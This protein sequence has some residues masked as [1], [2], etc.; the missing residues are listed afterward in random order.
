MNTNEF[1]IEEF[2]NYCCPSCNKS[3]ASL[4]NKIEQY[5]ISEP[6]MVRNL[7]FYRDRLWDDQVRE[8]VFRKKR[9]K[10]GDKEFN[11]EAIIALRAMADKIENPDGGFMISCELPS[12]PIFSGED[13]FGASIH[14]CFVK[15]PLGG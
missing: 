5:K 13:D 10:K 4:L 11:K 8:K 15:A 7:E 12:V 2:I 6:E 1:N 14:I 3:R 9:S